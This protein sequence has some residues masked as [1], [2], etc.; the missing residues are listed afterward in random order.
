MC[1]C[2]I[3]NLWKECTE[4]APH[5]APRLHSRRAHLIWI[6]FFGSLSEPVIHPHQFYI[7]KRCLWETTQEEH[8]DR[9]ELKKLEEIQANSFHVLM[10]A[11]APE[12]PVTIIAATA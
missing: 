11:D 12:H 4:T 5:T 7:L 9:T 10:P 2:V 8:C 3:C 1:V 6:V